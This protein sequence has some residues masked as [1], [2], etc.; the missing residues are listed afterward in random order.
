MSHE[1]GPRRRT[2]ART[3]PHKHQWSI[4][5]HG[6]LPWGQGAWQNGRGACRASRIFP[7]QLGLRQVTNEFHSGTFPKC[8]G[9]AFAGYCCLL[10]RVLFT[11]NIF[12][13]ILKF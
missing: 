2:S 1:S 13:E 5:A 11:T 12:S 4:K 6:V 3:R 10:R 7:R 9:Y 8:L